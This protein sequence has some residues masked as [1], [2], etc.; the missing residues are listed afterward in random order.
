MIFQGGTAEVF[1]QQH[2]AQ[3]L[4]AIGKVGAFI[5]GNLPEGSAE[6]DVK[7]D[8][9]ILSSL[10]S[11]VL[12]GAKATELGKAFLLFILFR[13]YKMFPLLRTTVCSGSFCSSR[14]LRHAR[15]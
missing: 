2:G 5:L 4:A 13:D 7:T 6:T 1:F 10:T 14:K 15:A 12:S 9:E 8:F 3:Y 11:K